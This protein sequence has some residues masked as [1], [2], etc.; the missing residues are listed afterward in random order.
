M[1]GNRLKTRIQEILSRADVEIDG[2]RPWDITVHDE[3]VYGR[4]LR[5]GSVGLG[6]SYMDDSWDCPALDQ[7]FCKVFIAGIERR[8]ARSLPAIRLF[9]KSL[10]CNL[11][12]KSRST[13]VAK[14]HY[15]LGNDLFQCML[16]QR[17]VYTCGKWESAGSLDE[18][19]EAK[20]D[21][22]CRKLELVPGMKVLD[23]GCGWGSFAKFAA[24]KYGVQ[25]IGITLSRQQLELGRSLCVG[26]P[27]DLRLA[28][29]R[30]LHDSFDRIVSLGMFEHVGSQNYRTFF[31]VAHRSLRDGGR[32]FLSTIGSN[33]S[34][35]MTDPWIERYIFPNSH[36][37]SIRQI[38]AALRG[39]FLVQ[40]WQNWGMDYDRTLMAWF[41]NVEAN[42]D[43]LKAIYSERFYRM[44]KFYLLASAGSFRS[45]RLQVWQISLSR[46]GGAR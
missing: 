20:L 33:T 18:A 16:D 24:E 31:N 27:V 21:F 46:D 25:V 34:V 30:D 15:D 35:R 17:M 38:E 23:I 28:D 1:S 45:H 42:W 2:S 44:W 7:F 19:Q 4:V 36:L 37:P 10:F 5:Q 29:Y 26:L 22:V 14:E 40:D 43:K 41:H 32:L 11:Q 13:K 6:E 12:T 3:N 8:A 39:R 9:V